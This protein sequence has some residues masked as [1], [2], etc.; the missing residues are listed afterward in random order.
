M[1]I[2]KQLGRLF[3]LLVVIFSL[4]GLAGPVAYFTLSE[5]YSG[6][7]NSTTAYAGFLGF[8]TSTSYSASSNAGMSLVYISLVT[9]IIALLVALVWL[10]YS[11]IEL[12]FLA[13]IKEIG[14]PP[15]V[16]KLVPWSPL[17]AGIF[18][19]LTVILY[20]LGISTIMNSVS[21]KIPSGSS[22]TFSWGLAV[23]GWMIVLAL[24]L[25]FVS[26]AMPYILKPKKAAEKPSS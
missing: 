21:S 12:P 2:A 22:I 5:S 24:I 6:F 7:S 11:L 4:I 19:L 17:L 25:C 23:G 20:Y 14:L 15:I 8:I 9:M 3:A 1:D 10:V 26:V 16:K 18:L 13:P